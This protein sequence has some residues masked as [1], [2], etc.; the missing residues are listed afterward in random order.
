MVK[1]DTDYLRDFVSKSDIDDFN[2]KLKLAH[3][4]LHD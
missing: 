4:K 1:L 3:T 2:E